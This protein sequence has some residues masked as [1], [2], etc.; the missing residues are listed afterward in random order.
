MTDDFQISVYN[1]WLLW[2]HLHLVETKYLKG[3][4]IYFWR[5]YINLEKP[6]KYQWPNIWWVINQ[7]VELGKI[8]DLMVFKGY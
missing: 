7:C 1:T 4:F 6:F 3:Q 2:C 5:E 8:R